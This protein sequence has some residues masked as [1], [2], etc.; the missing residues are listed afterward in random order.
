MLIRIYY[1]FGLTE[2]R[3]AARVLNMESSKNKH[4]SFLPE[5]FL[6]GRLFKNLFYIYKIAVYQ[7]KNILKI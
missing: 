2:I 6:F 4:W 7:S 3:I 5:C 1:S